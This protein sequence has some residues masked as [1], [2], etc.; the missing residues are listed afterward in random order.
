[1]SHLLLV[2]DDELL[3]DGLQA[4]LA[5]GGHQVRAAPDA[6]TAQPLLD[7]ERFDAVVLDLGLPGMDGI[8]LLQWIR[9]RFTALPVLI[10]TARDDVDD[11]IRGLTAGADDYLTKPFNVAELQARLL[12]LL[13]RAR[14]PAF[15]GSLEVEDAGE[16]RLRLDP[17]KPLAWLNGEALEVTQREWS[18]LTLLVNNMGQVV[19]REDVLAVWQSDGAETASNALEVY[20]HRLRRKLADSALSIRNVRGLG[21]ML[22][23][24]DS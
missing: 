15:G 1:M 3:R 6:E 9:Q 12:A 24:A 22:E 11:R 14:L 5:R 16:N 19:G 4:Q 2:E 20:V 10:L 13:R 17:H 8:A 23:R 21:Y 7:A 18:L